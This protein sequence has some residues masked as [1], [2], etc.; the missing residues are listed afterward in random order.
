LAPAILND[1]VRKQ[2]ENS[3]LALEG[4]A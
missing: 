1:A 2:I 3:A 4:A